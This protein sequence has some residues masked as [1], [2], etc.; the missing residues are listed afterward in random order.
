MHGGRFT[1]TG[2]R[3]LQLPIPAALF[4]CPVF[5]FYPIDREFAIGLNANPLHNGHL[6]IGLPLYIPMYPHL[7]GN[8]LIATSSY[9]YPIHYELYE[10]LLSPSYSNRVLSDIYIIGRRRSSK[11]FKKKLWFVFQGTK[12]PCYCRLCKL[13]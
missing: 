12:C 10:S 7:R 9:M 8:V 11:L 3:E 2:G 5:S 4:F 6:L 13:R 1:C